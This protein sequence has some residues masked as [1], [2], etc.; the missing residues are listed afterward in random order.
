[1][2]KSHSQ[3][4]KYASNLNASKKRGLK[5][6]KARIK[7]G[8]LVCFVSDISGRWS[9]DSPENYKRACQVHL[10]NEEKTTPI[11]HTMRNEAES[12]LN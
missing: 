9:V 12:E 3:K 10:E 4:T 5:K 6:I 11:T 8:E 7:S 2:A 1:M